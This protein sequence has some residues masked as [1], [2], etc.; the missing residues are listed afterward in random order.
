M[1]PDDAIVGLRTRDLDLPREAL[2]NVIVRGGEAIP[3]RGS[4]RVE[5][6][7]RLHL[8]IRQE[9]APEVRELLPRWRTGPIGPGTVERPRLAGVSRVFHTR[10]WNDEEDGDAQRPAEVTGLRVID[11]VRSRRDVP[12]A[13][14]LLEDGRYAITGPVL[15]FGSRQALSD[16]VRRRIRAGVSD[17]ERVWWEEVLGALAL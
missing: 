3:P 7:D 12:G 15:A 17:T 10:P 11:R 16:W 13:L 5:E 6:G 1:L 14:V 8:L 2:V 9:V 4:T